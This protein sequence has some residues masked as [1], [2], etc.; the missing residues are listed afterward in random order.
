MDYQPFTP[1]LTD[2]GG[3]L[4]YIRFVRSTEG[5][6]TTRSQCR[7]RQS[8]GTFS[9]LSCQ[10]LRSEILY[11]GYIFTFLHI[12]WEC[13]S[14]KLFYPTW[15]MPTQKLMACCSPVTCLGNPP[16]SFGV[17]SRAPISP[18]YFVA[19]QYKFLRNHPMILNHWYLDIYEGYS[20]SKTEHQSSRRPRHR[21]GAGCSGQSSKQFWIPRKIRWL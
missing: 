13:Q 19:S 9:M 7:N 6:D 4:Y 1:A 21:T 12:Q 3:I 8:K 20:S 14:F 18:T 11:R 5:L 2:Q 17:H 16:F 15:A 10:T